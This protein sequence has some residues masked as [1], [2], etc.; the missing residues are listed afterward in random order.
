MNWSELT[1][2]RWERI[3]DK[4]LSVLVFQQGFG[5]NVN[6]ATC[7]QTENLLLHNWIGTHQIAPNGVTDVH[8][9]VSHSGFWHC[10][11]VF[12]CVCVTKEVNPHSGEY[13]S[14][15]AKICAHNS[16]RTKGGAL[17]DDLGN[18]VKGK[19]FFIGC[20]LFPSCVHRV[21]QHLLKYWNN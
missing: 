17:R 6:V 3:Q 15:D 1:R 9:F 2:A 18:P 4:S 20:T 10:L 13:Q 7:D 12:E 19:W 16:R 5:N 11:T 8:L 14:G 21:I